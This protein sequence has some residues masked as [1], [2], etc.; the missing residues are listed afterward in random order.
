MFTF[1]PGPGSSVGGGMQLTQ[2]E[3]CWCRVKLATSAAIPLTVPVGS[4]L[5]WNYLKW[6]VTAPRVKFDVVGPDGVRTGQWVPLQRST[7]DVGPTQPSACVGVLINEFGRGRVVVECRSLVFVKR[8]AVVGA[9][10]DDGSSLLHDLL[11]CELRAQ[12]NH[13]RA[14]T[15]VSSGTPTG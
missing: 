13:R 9:D 15:P 4:H 6:N 1:T 2:R 8:L 14:S 7:V 3:R 5:S 12:E 10:I 11:I